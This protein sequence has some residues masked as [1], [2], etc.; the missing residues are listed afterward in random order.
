MTPQKRSYPWTSDVGGH[1]ITFRLMTPADKEPFRD[2][3]RS[4]PE[5]DN[6]FLL[7]DVRQDRSLDHW[8]R[9]VETGRTISVIALENG[10]MVGYGNLHTSELNWTRHVGEVRL[11]VARSHRGRG[12]GKVLA[13][14]VF[15][16]ARSRGL[17]KIMAR[18]ASSQTG[19][20][21]VFASLG[22]QPEALLA[23]FVIDA[24]G[25]TQDLV[26]MSHDVTGFVN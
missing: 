15:S 20:R 25:R 3:V 1:P 11:Q 17:Q 24:Q 14:E 2:F 21:Q 13:Q 19:A 7:L 26:I 22:F 8:M 5:E 6:F 4:V 16:I 9:G 18:M 23:D 12:L 10:K